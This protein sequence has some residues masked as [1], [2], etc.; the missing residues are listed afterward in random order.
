MGFNRKSNVAVEKILKNPVYSGMLRVES[1][2]EFPGGLFPGIHE[3]IIDK[4]TWRLVQNKINEPKRTRAIL[5]EQLP[6]RGIL[7]CHCGNA[8]TGA[9]SRG[10]SGKYFYYYKCKFSGH[11]NLSAIKIHD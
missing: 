8:L 6:L 4:D 5:D 2:R 1:F 11:N 3:A 10:K 9:P 7:K